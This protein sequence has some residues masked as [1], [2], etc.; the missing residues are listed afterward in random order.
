MIRFAAPIEV[1][2][3]LPQHPGWKWEYFGG[4]VVASPRPKSRSCVKTFGDGDPLDAVPPDLR[5]AALDDGSPVSTRPLTDADWDVLPGVLHGA[6][7]RTAPFAQMTAERS[8]EVAGE[9]MENVRAGQW[10]PLIEPAC[11]IIE[12]E[13]KFRRKEDG[14]GPVVLGTVLVTLY[15]PSSDDDP[16][17][18]WRPAKDPPDD[19]LETNWGRPHLTWVFVNGWE[20]RHGLGTCLLT[21][22]CR[23]LQSLGYGE[24]TSTFLTGNHQSAFWHWRNGFRLL[25]GPMSMRPHRM[26]RFRERQ[27]RRRAERS[28]EP[29]TD[30]VPDA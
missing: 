29:A 12:G 24:L 19:W 3:R 23:A 25:T 7:G 18:E 13:P 8:Q 16:L 28:D 26:N 20:A 15:R 9:C 6:F 14:E 22:A 30:S 1:Y 2:H 21:D 5:D 11:L 17:F 10:G 4:E 27:E